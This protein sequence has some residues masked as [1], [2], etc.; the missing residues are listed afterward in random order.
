MK[1]QEFDIMAKPP[2]IKKM[3]DR[4]NKLKKRMRDGLTTPARGSIVPSGIIGIDLITKG[5]W[6]FGSAHEFY[7]FSKTAK[8]YV[9]QKIAANAQAFIP[10]CYV[11]Y[12]DR[13]N[14]CDPERVAS[15][16]FDL[17]RTIIIP[18]NEIPTPD[19]AF[20][21]MFEAAKEISKA[22]VEGED[23]AKAAKK[24]AKEAKSAGVEAVLEVPEQKKEKEPKEDKEDKNKFN[25]GYKESFPHI[26]FI[27]D[28]VPAFAEKAEMTEDQG[29]RAKWWHIVMR[30]IT[31]FVDPKIMVLFSNQICYDPS[32][33]SPPTKKSGGTALDYYREIGLELE[34]MWTIQNEA[35]I[36][37]GPMIHARVKKTRRAGGEGKTFFPIYW[38]GGAPQFAGILPYMEYLGMAEVSNKTAF[39]Q[40]KGKVWAN[41]SVKG[42]PGTINE[43]D[44]ERLE[45]FV[46]EHDIITKIREREK[47]LFG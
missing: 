29:R 3:D 25:R 6:N 31:A 35:G 9:M 32:P 17:N 30:R 42:I 39:A 43:V 33:Y 36:E 14:S 15:V 47:E 16:G 34:L 13:E 10:D 5:G 28:S 45:T 46:R 38:K 1:P 19:A 7:G 12:L 24:A 27:I 8:S 4:L 21:A 20:T 2:A 26:V 18:S 44:T 22:H 11:V 37:V 41:Y 23:A 40:G